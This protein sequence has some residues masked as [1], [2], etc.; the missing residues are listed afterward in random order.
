MTFTTEQAVTSHPGG[1]S[2]TCSR[3]THR[4][5]HTSIAAATT[6]AA[7]PAQTTPDGCPCSASAVQSSSFPVQ[8]CACQPRSEPASPSKSPSVSSSVT[9][10]TSPS[11]SPPKSPSKSPSISPSVPIPP[12]HSLNPYTVPL[13]STDGHTMFWP[14]SEDEKRPMTPPAVAVSVPVFHTDDARVE[15]EKSEHDFYR[16]SSSTFHPIQLSVAPT[17][18]SHEDPA[19]L[20]HTAAAPSFTSDTLFHAS[21]NHVPPQLAQTH[22]LAHACNTAPPTGSC[23]AASSSSSHPLPSDLEV[24]PRGYS[25]QEQLIIE[26]YMDDTPGTSITNNRRGACS[27]HQNSISLRRKGRGTSVDHGRSRKAGNGKRSGDLSRTARTNDLTAGNTGVSSNVSGS[28]SVS[29]RA[30]PSS[31]PFSGATSYHRPTPPGTTHDG[32]NSSSTVAPSHEKPTGPKASSFSAFRQTLES[33]VLPGRNRDDQENTGHRD[34]QHNVRWEAEEG[35]LPGSSRHHL[36]KNEPQRISPST[37]HAKGVFGFKSGQQKTGV[38]GKNGEEPETDVFKFVD[39]ILNMPDH[40]TG[41]QVTWKLLKVLVVMTFAYF[42]LMALYFAAE[43]QVSDRMSNLDVLVV[44]LDQSLIGALFLNFTQM[45][46]KDGR[47]NLAI[48][49]YDSI[50]AVKEVVDNGDYW[51]AIVVN[52]GA[53]STLN[54][55]VSVPIADYRPENAFTLIYDGGRDPLVVKPLI[56]AQMHRHFM[57]FVGEFNTQWVYLVLTV[58]AQDNQ[59]LTPL[60]GAPQALGAPIAF[61]EADLHEATAAIITSATSVAYIWIFFVAGAST[62]LVANIV[63]PLA[64]KASVRRTML[65]L[66]LPLF[67]FLCS[68]SMTYSVLLRIFGV[69]FDSA[70]QFAALFF[71]MVLLQSAVASLVLFLIFLIPVPLIPII[72]TIFVVMNVIAVF[73][74]VEL[75][76]PFYR[77]V[78]AMPFLNAVQAVRF[79]LLGSYN[80]LVYNLPILFAWVMVPITLLP[81]AI[82]RQKRLLMEVRDLERRHLPQQERYEHAKK[83]R[84]HNDRQDDEDRHGEGVFSKDGN[85]RRSRSRTQSKSA[86][87]RRGRNP[88]RHFDD[89][90]EKSDEYDT[91]ESSY[92]PPQAEWADAYSDV[93]GRD[94]AEDD[95]DFY[96][97]HAAAYLSRPPRNAP[98][99]ISGVSP[100]APPEA[101]VFDTHNRL[102]AGS[103]DGRNRT[104]IE[105]PRLNRHPY[106]AELVR[107]QTLSEVK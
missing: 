44:D 105:M 84:P 55:A 99:R 12:R 11:I 13:A 52:E 82:T 65:L 14:S 7:I 59:T 96:D 73:H 92:D 61:N 95:L 68:L 58:A 35:A 24:H 91:S 49:D 100:S 104:F 98:T 88:E 87:R 1:R 71:A 6:A 45:S 74:P 79:V 76:P 102:A 47:I 43:F 106:A 4:L 50:D 103:Q 93:E 56:V 42:A 63:Q 62:Y 31:S 10:S 20:Y 77:W 101:L 34:D 57:E 60:M 72:T 107:S 16:Y 32:S 5:D 48:R 70:G 15:R 9:S 8:A 29:S 25:S 86:R 22:T 26:T 75:M 21:I 51:G 36:R 80:R 66:L 39:I 40:P 3:P 94:G 19:P 90:R 67:V 30:G 41:R 97:T 27:R 89:S 46:A 33:L 53:S 78:Y 69:P 28:S 64:R 37:T 54:K 18:S 83:R 17:A 85:G 23:N 38:P 81:F 2:S